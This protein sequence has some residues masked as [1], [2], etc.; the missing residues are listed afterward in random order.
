MDTINYTSLSKAMSKA[1]RHRPERI[2]ITLSPDGSVEVDVLV[3][4]LNQRGGWPRAITADDIAHVVKHGSKQRFAME[5]G[6]IRALYGHS[7]PLAIAYEPAQPPSVLYHGTNQANAQ[8]IMVE[9]L[10]PMGRQVVHLST[11]VETARQVGLRHRGCLVILVVDAA[12][13]SHDGIRFYQGNK[14]TWLADAIPA[15]YLRQL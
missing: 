3:R 5:R 2:G 11:D 10:L 12:E 4:A 13:A 15:D 1:L 7:I 14:N 9:G 8:S 6:R